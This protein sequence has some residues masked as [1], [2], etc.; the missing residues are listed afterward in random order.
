MLLPW[1][2]LSFGSRMYSCKITR[3][4]DLSGNMLGYEQYKFLPI[5]WLDLLSHMTKAINL[6]VRARSRFQRALVLARTHHTVEVGFPV[7][8]TDFLQC[9][10]ATDRTARVWRFP[11]ACGDGRY[12]HN[13]GMSM[14]CIDCNITM[15]LVDGGGGAKRLVALCLDRSKHVDARS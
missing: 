8:T 7:S 15:L 4:E 13:A 9:R 14:G 12:L 3:G 2:V 5:V 11:K 6:V 1:L 10:R